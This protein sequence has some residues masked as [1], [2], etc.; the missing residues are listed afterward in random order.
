MARLNRTW[1]GIFALGFVPLAMAA[2]PTPPTGTPQVFVPW[3]N[4]FFKKDNPP[5]VI[6]HDFG[7]VPHGTMLTHKFTFTNIYDVPMQI[8][9]V[10]KSCTC[11]DADPPQKVLQPNE[12]ADIVLT[13]NAAKF[14][15]PNAQ[16]F[17]VTFGPQ[18]VS[19]AV[20]RVQANSRA[21]VQLSPGHVN[22]GVV[23]QGAKAAQV[24]TIKYVGKMR[25]WKITEVVKPSGPLDVQLTDP[26]GPEF[27]VTV[28]LKADA[29]AGTILEPITL[30]TNDPTAS[31]LQFNVAGVVQAP[32]TVA[33]EKVKFEGVKLGDEQTQKVILRATKAFKV[34]AV[35]DA[36]D[37]LTI[38]PGEVASPVQIITVKFKPVG[39]GAWK[40]ELKLKTDLGEAPLTVELEA[41]Q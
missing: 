11:L 15:G 35:A 4:K 9:D 36:G 41:V 16:T 38:E 31:L 13:M 26:K 14:N 17:Y 30:K 12:S 34:E 3:A 2:E 20:I 19:T 39:T 40:R 27:A 10:R 32:I 22:F 23:Q 8:I 5:S 37:G 25:D 1:L 21:D 29:P 28:S 7:T 24:V 18:Y 33:P 6:V